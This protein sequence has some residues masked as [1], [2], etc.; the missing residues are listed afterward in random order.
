MRLY[1]Q[2]EPVPDVTVPIPEYMLE[3]L[4]Q[5]EGQCVLALYDDQN[6]L[7]QS[8]IAPKGTWE[9]EAC[10]DGAAYARYTIYCM[11]TQYVPLTA[12]YSSKG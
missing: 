9:M 3:A 1:A 5:S 10:L 2:W 12:P 8:V 11:D 6:R 4:D 7:V